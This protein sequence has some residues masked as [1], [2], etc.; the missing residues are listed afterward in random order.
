MVKVSHNIQKRSKVVL[1]FET[2]SCK[3]N[4]TFL[5]TEAVLLYEESGFQPT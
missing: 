1:C 3:A 4:S 5:A 2:V